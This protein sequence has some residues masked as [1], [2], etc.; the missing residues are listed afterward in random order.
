MKLKEAEFGCDV[1][2]IPP[3]PKISPRLYRHKSAVEAAHKFIE[4]PLK[5]LARTTKQHIFEVDT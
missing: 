1:S 4:E 3:V 5:L 2:I